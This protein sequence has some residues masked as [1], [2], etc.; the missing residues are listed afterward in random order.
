M[1]Y[2]VRLALKKYPPHPKTKWGAISYPHGT[3]K[4][5]RV[6][7]VDPWG[8]YWRFTAQSSQLLFGEAFGNQ[9]CG[10]KHIW[11]HIICYFILTWFGS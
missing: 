8:D 6:L 10:C 4:I 5:C 1:I 3:S 2:D 7:G 11:Q 9:K